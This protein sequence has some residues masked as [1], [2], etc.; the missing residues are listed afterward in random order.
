MAAGLLI[1]PFL[2][3]GPIQ[4]LLNNLT[5][6]DQGYINQRSITIVYLRQGEHR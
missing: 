3:M 4:F 1:L 5:D 6:L 2:S